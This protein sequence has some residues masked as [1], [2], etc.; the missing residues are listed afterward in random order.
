MLQIFIKTQ[1][2]LKD[3]IFVY[4]SSKPV[5]SENLCSPEKKVLD[6][7]GSYINMSQTK[8]RNVCVSVICGL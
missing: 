8:I 5:L 2:A 1:N 3:R 4:S 7:N 6:P